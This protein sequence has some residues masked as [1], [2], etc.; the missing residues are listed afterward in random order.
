MR[1]AAL[2]ALRA[3]GHA[4]PNPLV[5]C[6][7]ERDG[8]VLAIGHHR[9]FGQI[10]AEV[11]ALSRCVALGHDPRGATMH[12]TL[13]P[14]CHTGKQPPCTDSILRAGIAKVVFAAFDPGEVSG[15]GAKI[16]AQAGVRVSHDP[17]DPLATGLSQPF[18]H[19]LRTARP[20]V[21]AKWAQTVD[22]RIATRT[23]HSQWIS[24]ELSRRKVHHLRARIDAIITGLGT[25]HA[26]DPLL[27][28]R[29]VSRQR[30]TAVRVVVD[31]HLDIPLHA[32]LVRTA[33][34]TPTLIAC[35][36]AMAVSGLTADKRAALAEQGVGLLPTPG[37]LDRLDLQALLELLASEHK[38]STVL[39]EAGSG[40]LGSMFEADLIDEAFVYIAPLLLGDEHAPAAA[41]GR[42]VERLDGG[43]PMRLIHT[44]R[45][46]DDVELWYRRQAD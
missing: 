4:E 34:T 45:L 1:R 6:L 28:A 7:I 10:H 16:L 8:Q 42:A 39:V 3:A 29:G 17:S 23:G 33:H 26:D 46:G 37:C 24:N 18:V 41:H 13:E 32:K 36:A 35:D 38:V 25:V 44:R 15:G 22:G 43:R 21:I 9:R 11:D 40:L 14:C 19:R 2:A 31:Q 12:V 27:T 20:W 5:G 30:R